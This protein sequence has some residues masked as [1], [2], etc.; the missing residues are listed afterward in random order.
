MNIK[1][2]ITFAALFCMA[3]VAQAQ[4][5]T[6]PDGN[7]VMNF[8]LNQAGAPT[9]DLYF[10]NKAVINPSTLGL[11]L[12]KKMPTS[13]ST[14]KQPNVQTLTNWMKNKFDDRIYHPGHKDQ[15]FRRNLETGMGRRKFHQKSLQ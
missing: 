11:E 7:L 10:K 15:Y 1:K 2:H 12:K 4:K 6:S 8:S 3:L 5:L 14:L 13:K 9:Y